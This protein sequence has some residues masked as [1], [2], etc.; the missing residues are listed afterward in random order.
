MKQ[1]KFTEQAQ[2]ALAL[3]Q[4]IVREQHHSQWDVEHILLALLRQE[5]GL[6]GEILAERV[7]RMG[8]GDDVREI[9][10]RA[11]RDQVEHQAGLRNHGEIRRGAG[12]KRGSQIGI[13]VCRALVDDRG[14]PVGL[15][16]GKGRFQGSDLV[17]IDLRAPDRDR[18]SADVDIGLP[19]ASGTRKRDEQ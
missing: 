6:V 14:A 4:E 10:Q 3:S 15:E 13:E 2:E 17:G 7:D 19:R 5:Q 8:P 9:D 1:E 11:V 16:H 18:G 12:S